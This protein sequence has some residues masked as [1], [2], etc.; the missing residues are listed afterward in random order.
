MTK[1]ICM[2]FCLTSFLLILNTGNWW[3]VAPM[4]GFQF[5]MIL[6]ASFEDRGRLRGAPLS[7]NVA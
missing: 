4:I 6:N 5:L 1:Y 2:F 3:F 7:H